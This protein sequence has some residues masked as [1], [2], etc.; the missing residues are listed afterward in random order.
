MES[1]YNGIVL[2]GK[3]VRET[4]RMYIVY[5]L[6]AGKIKVMGTGVRKP[7]AKLAGFLEPITQG[8]IFIAK[9]KGI[10]KITGA[11]AIDYYYGIKSNLESLQKAFY[12]F[13]FIE[14]LFSDQEKDE[15]SFFILS[16]FLK[17]LDELSLRDNTGRNG[18]DILVAGCL[19]QLLAQLGYGLEMDKCVECEKRLVLERNFFSVSRGG[20]LCEKCSLLENRKMQISPESIKMIRL[21]KS[22]RLESLVKLKVNEKNIKSLN[23][24]V[25]EA[26]NWII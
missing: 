22:N 21:I 19:F 25:K 9:G 5:T 23:L 2:K 24:L 7:D 16:S 18:M 13:D 3:N 12:V 1:K 8:E 20:I 15:K 14:K 6:E 26:V 17:T 10:G 11:I 4:D